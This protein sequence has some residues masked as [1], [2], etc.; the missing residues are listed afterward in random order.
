[1]YK[2]RTIDVW[3]T[4]LRRDCHP[5]CIK[6]GIARFLWLLGRDDLKEQFQDPW[7]LYQARIE[8]ERELAAISK[9][10]GKDGEYQ[11]YEV[12]KKWIE[13]TYLK[14]NL[15]S[16]AERIVH[17]EF[18]MEVDRSEMDPGILAFLKKFPAEKTLFLS[19]F[20]MNSGMLRALLARKGLADVVNMGISSCDVGL[21]KR[22]GRLFAYIHRTFDV[23]PNEHVHVGD[24][25]WS[26][27]EVPQKAGVHAIHYSP[28]KFHAKRLEREALFQSRTILFDDIRMKVLHAC[29][30][31]IHRKSLGQA[32]AFRAGTE[33]A[34]LFVGFILWIAEE[35]VARKLDEIYFLTR[36]GEFFQNIF[37]KVFPDRTLAGHTLPCG[38]ILETSRLATFVAT[39]ETASIEEM[40][41]IWRLF[42]SQNVRGLFLTLGID[43][44][45]FDNVLSEA[46][47][48]LEEC[49]ENPESNRSLA[50]L[51]SSQPFV[52]ALKDSIATR[53]ELLKTFLEAKGLSK[54]KRIGIVDIG[55]RGT[56]QDNLATVMPN[57]SFEGLYMGLRRFLNS[58]PKNVWKAAY[59][60]DE[61]RE[62]DVSPLFETFAAI[63]MLCMLPGGSVS[64]YRRSEDGRVLPI[65]DS[66][67]EEEEVLKSYVAEFQ[68]GVLL[69]ADFWRSA[70]ERYSVGSYELR[71]FALSVWKSLRICPDR[72]L[73]S[74]FIQSNQHDVFGFGEVFKRNCAPSLSTLILWPILPSRRRKLVEYI[75]RI[76]W[77]AAVNGISGIGKLH[78]NVLILL[79]YAANYI[80]RIRARISY[81]A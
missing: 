69:A 67:A 71:P 51:F 81:R 62:G 66:C 79:F 45:G 50:R 15:S 68:S 54:G 11:L 33:M 22:S 77:P 30:D 3:D 37:D 41:R 2:I 60:P 70:I 18:E 8:V 38:V 25:I 73:L 40:L 14:S 75:R 43:P 27:V 10:K 23:K 20:Y 39:L 17:V 29:E 35:A 12:I 5:E 72:E 46:G 53:K 21:N 6:L 13:K 34:P 78:R 74:A 42:G 49:V 58:Q 7:I 9:S 56:I 16:L 65:R 47:L 63:E 59:G 64:G 28:Q 31:I 19:D 52:H 4:L 32:A 57:I 44:R 48:S 24:N 76:Q 1:M 55:W 26:D 80:R 61:N 36:E